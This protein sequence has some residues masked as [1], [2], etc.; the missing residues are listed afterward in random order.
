MSDPL[1]YHLRHAGPGV[2]V[3]DLVGDLTDASEGALMS[4]YH[5]AT[6]AGA[7]TIVLQC[8]RLGY[9]NN[10]GIGVLVTLLVRAGR[11]R[12]RLLACELSDHYRQILELTRLDEA[13]GVHASERDA[14]A[15]AGLAPTA[16]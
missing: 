9:M 4:A 14:L 1:T 6:I 7:R 8:T 5:E 12:Q 10:S 13:I 11:Q 16:A 15:A 3:V 2:S